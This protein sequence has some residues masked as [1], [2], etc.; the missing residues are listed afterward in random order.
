MGRRRT[1]AQPVYLARCHPDYPWEAGRFALTALLTDTERKGRRRGLEALVPD[2]FRD[3]AARQEEY[4]RQLEHVVDQAEHED[5][6]AVVAIVHGIG[7]SASAEEE[8]YAA[9]LQRPDAPARQGWE[10]HIVQLRAR[11][12]ELAWRAISG[13]QAA[14][15]NES[16]GRRREA[17]AR[18]RRVWRAAASRR[19]G[20]PS[21]QVGD[22][23]DVAVSYW[24][25]VFRFRQVL[26]VMKHF[27]GDLEARFRLAC[28]VG[29][30]PA[31]ATEV[32]ITLSDFSRP[33][34][35]L[36]DGTVVWR[37]SQRARPEALAHL[38]TARRH[39]LTSP[40]LDDLLA[41]YRLSRPPK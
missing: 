12:R 28:D 37:P 9:W 22:D 20:R 21:T 14:L 40:Q 6:D 38:V 10:L 15:A 16:P 17:R 23:R 1:G 11:A 29:E 32:G 18:L 39:H 33:M 19:P 3:H 13:W 2:L 30:L 4:V 34:G 26:A 41:G 36:P 31:L 25:E 27:G 5:V 35:F 24:R 7:T 8:D